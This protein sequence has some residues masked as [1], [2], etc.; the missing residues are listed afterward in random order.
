[1]KRT[2]LTVLVCGL[3]LTLNSCSSS[4]CTLTGIASATVKIANAAADNITDPSDENCKKYRDALQSY[5]DKYED[6]DL[7]SKDEIAA[8]KKSI[9]D[10]NCN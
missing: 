10:L 8:H 1:M 9:E 6:C 4:G 3:F 2:I 5:I 7:A